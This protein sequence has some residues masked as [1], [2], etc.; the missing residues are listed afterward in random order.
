MKIHWSKEGDMYTFNFLNAQLINHIKSIAV[1]KT[2]RRY[3]YAI[4]TV[5]PFYKYKRKSEVDQVFSI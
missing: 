3:T 2:L 1:R 4:W 5:L